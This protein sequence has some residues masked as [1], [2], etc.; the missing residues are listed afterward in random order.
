MNI[1]IA[2]LVF[3]CRSRK[4]LWFIFYQHCYFSHCFI[5][6]F[7]HCWSSDWYCDAL[8]CCEEEMPKVL[9]PYNSPQAAEA[10]ASTTVWG[11][12]CTEENCWTLSHWTE[13]EH[14]IWAI[15]RLTEF[16]IRLPH[17]KNNT[18]LLSVL[19]IDKRH[20]MYKTNQ[21]AH[22]HNRTVS[23]QQTKYNKTNNEICIYFV[24]ICM[25]YTDVV[26]SPLSA[27]SYL[28]AN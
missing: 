27:C 4:H 23:L 24:M 18:S 17:N 13:G 15:A 3:F 11:H 20:I 16:V 22:Q 6:G 2:I 26:L 1:G 28:M 25:Y 12:H 10:T 21:Q 7:T 19:E 5:C 14:C 9:L 8:L